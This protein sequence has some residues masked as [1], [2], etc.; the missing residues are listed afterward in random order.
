MN[1]A[2]IWNG[3]TIVY[4]QPGTDPLQ[5]ENQDR[6]TT[7]V[8]I[9]RASTAGIFNAVTETSYVK[10]TSPAGTEWAVGDLA[11]ATDSHLYHLGRCG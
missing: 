2:T 1:A 11:D 9:T 7:N 6:I 3:P 4:T 5:P 10:P 8:W